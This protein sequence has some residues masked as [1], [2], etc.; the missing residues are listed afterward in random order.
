MKMRANTH[1]DIMDI[2][3]DNLQMFLTG[4]RKIKDFKEVTNALGKMS[5]EKK[6]L[7]IY[8]SVI[9]D[10]SNNVEWYSSSLQLPDEKLLENRKSSP[11]KKIK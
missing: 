8:K 6:N 9:G 1:A 2:H 11:L 4:K 3:N 10:H 5:A 7:L